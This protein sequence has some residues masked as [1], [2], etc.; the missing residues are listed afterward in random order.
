MSVLVTSTPIII[1]KKEVTRNAGTGET[2]K[3]GETDKN[4][5]NSK[6]DKN[7]EKNKNLK[8]NFVQILY[9]YYP[10]TF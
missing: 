1:A 6:N 5:K 2:G 10:I 7:K 8:I 4:S 3:D 9:I